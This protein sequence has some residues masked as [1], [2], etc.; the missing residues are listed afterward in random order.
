MALQDVLDAFLEDPEAQQQFES[1]PEGYLS[2]HGYEDVEAADVQSAISDAPTAEPEAPAEE[3]TEEAPEAPAAEETPTYETEEP[4]EEPAPTNYGGD[5]V[6]DSSINQNIETFGD[7]TQDFD[8]TDV[9]GEDA[10]SSGDY[11]QVNTGDEAIQTGGDVYDSTQASGDVAGSVT[12]DNYDSV[13]GDGNAVI[14]DSS[15]GSASFGGGD[16][17]NIQGENVNLGDGNIQDDTFG[18]ASLNAGAGDFTS[19][20]DSIVSESSLGEGDVYS[21]D[22]TVLADNGSSV[23][24]GEGSTS[25]AEDQDTSIYG[26][27]GNINVADDGDQTSGIDASTNDSFNTADSF[28]S[29]FDAQDNSINDSLNTEDSYN[30]F[31]DESDNSATESYTDNSDDD[32]TYTDNS[33]SDNDHED[34]DVNGG[35]AYEAPA[36]GFDVG[37][38]S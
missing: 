16:S 11:S 7:V 35:D 34:Y 26:N 29:A 38:G 32:Y 13:V 8:R 2:E 3:T 10:V 23:A 24:F 17:S 4:T 14:D 22:P 37:M 5:T 18:D 9:S 33:A 30:S 12:G 1:D 6:S 21:D 19:V 36:E 27:S 20:D 15:V 31:L 25:S 28:N